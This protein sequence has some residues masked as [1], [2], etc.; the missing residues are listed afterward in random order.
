MYNNIIYYIQGFIQK[1]Q[2]GVDGDVDIVAVSC[3]A[4]NN[5]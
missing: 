5:C 1:F 2:F 3:T 4:K